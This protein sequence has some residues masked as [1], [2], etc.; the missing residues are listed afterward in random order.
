M[1]S[2]RSSVVSSSN[3]A[4]SLE[5]ICIGGPYSGAA[6]DSEITNDLINT[7]NTQSIKTEDCLTGD[8]DRE[9]ASKIYDFR[10]N[11]E[12]FKGLRNDKESSL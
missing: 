11:D 8:G 4:S 10:N 3:A 5:F 12:V 2:S 6:D 7:I 9:V 1:G